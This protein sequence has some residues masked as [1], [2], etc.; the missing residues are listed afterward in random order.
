MNALLG[1]LSNLMK[2]AFQKIY[3]IF[4]TIIIQA[5][6]DFFTNV[7]EYFISLDLSKELHTAFVMSTEKTAKNP[8]SSLIADELSGK[9]IIEGVYN[10]ATDS[11]DSLRYIGGEGVDEK[12]ENII[13]DNP[14]V[15]FN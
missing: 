10:K 7:I 12:T 2:T 13:K 3:E 5:V 9:G 1:S 14:V 11:I 6:V 4:I 15:V 8:F